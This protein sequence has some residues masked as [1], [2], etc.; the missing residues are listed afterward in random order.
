M[1]VL[2]FLFFFPFEG[3]VEWEE[4]ANDKEMGPEG[5]GKLLD[6]LTVFCS[7]R[8]EADLVGL[9]STSGW[10]ECLSLRKASK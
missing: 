1:G 4:E 2:G 7:P 9:G 3:V 8:L 10:K 6:A 5:R